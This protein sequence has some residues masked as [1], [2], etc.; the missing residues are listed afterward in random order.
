MR[1]KRKVNKLRGRIMG[2]LTKNVGTSF[3]ANERIADVSQVK[4]ILISRPNHRLGNQLLLTPLVQ[5]V[6]NTFPNC[7]IDLFVKGGVANLVF[8]NYDRI[9]TIIELP[10][11]PFNKLL[12]YG[13]TWLKLKKRK[14][15]LVINVDK[16]SSSG[17]LSTKF[18]RGTFKI[19]GDVNEDILKQFKDH[20]HMSKYPIY[21][22][23]YYL[24]A[25]GLP[26]NT[27]P[28]PLLDI[29]LT[30]EEVSKGKAIL[31]DLV[32]NS[33]PILC[34]YTNAT[35]N[36][37]YSED[38]WEQFY[39]RLLN[40]YPNYNIIELLP[41]E[42]ISRI[43]FKAPHFYSKDVREMGGVLRNIDVFIAA[44]NGVMHLASASLVT[45][46]GFFKTT[47]EAIYAPYGNGSFDINTNDTLI[48]DWF[49]QIDQLL[50]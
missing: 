17:R 46:V 1:F 42:N 4:R 48:D 28:L 9:D 34:I 5:E 2:R 26:K 43:G 30:E 19:F 27:N 45:T 6:E 37:C 39:Q 14:Y 7:K 47:K 44:D 11:K 33:K 23:R 50:G 32:K 40:D 12:T 38:W 29:K 16:N 24:E 10:R 18:S 25:L 49:V 41:V 8:K 35:G 20:E 21:N 13:L 3:K 22:L 15:D 36:K 31:G